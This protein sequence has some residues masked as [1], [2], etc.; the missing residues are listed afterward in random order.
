MDDEP[1]EVFDILSAMAE[2]LLETDAI[3]RI[4]QLSDD[5]QTTTSIKIKTSSRKPPKEIFYRQTDTFTSKLPPPVQS[6]RCTNRYL[7]LGAVAVIKCL[8]CTIYDPLG[9]GYFCLLCFNSRHPWHRVPHFFTEIDRDESI[10]YTLQVAHRRVEVIRYEKEGKD[11]LT[12][13]KH[14]QKQ[15]QEEVADDEGVDN[16]IREAGRR[17]LALEMRM[18]SIRN[19]LR[20]DIVMKGGR[21][22]LVMNDEEAAFVI[23]RYL[24]GYLIRKMISHFYIGRI[25]RVWDATLGRDFYYDKATKLSS[26]SPPK[27]LFKHDIEKLQ[28]LEDKSAVYKWSAKKYSKRRRRGA[29]AITEV[30]MAKE[31][32][33]GYFHCIKARITTIKLAKQRYRRVWDEESSVYYYIDMRTH[34]STWTKPTIFLSQEPPLHVLLTEDSNGSQ[35]RSPRIN[36]FS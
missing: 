8:S 13:I 7:C 36:R 31:I 22:S 25:I 3:F 33:T 27:L 1:T 23:M 28:Y 32:L 6:R 5:K 9:L 21:D 16:R 11:V 2:S 20:R 14:G 10:E 12:R 30:L 26:W 19:T 18:R 4:S 35:R 29:P 24:R 34:E 15:L 17:T